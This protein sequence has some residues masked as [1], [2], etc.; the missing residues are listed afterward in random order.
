MA[1]AKVSEVIGEVFAAVRGIRGAT[2]FLRMETVRVYA[3]FPVVS[4]S[5][6]ASRR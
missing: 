1:V 2:S 6:S 5:T 3:D 4:S